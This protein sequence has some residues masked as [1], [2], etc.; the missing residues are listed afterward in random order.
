[1]GLVETLDFKRK[2]KKNARKLFSQWGKP[3]LL[4]LLKGIAKGVGLLLL[5]S[6]AH[7]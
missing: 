2:M 3:L 7:C 1:V 4:E 5:T 6:L